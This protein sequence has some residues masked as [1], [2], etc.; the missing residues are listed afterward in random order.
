MLKEYPNFKRG[1]IDKFHE[2]L[3][4]QE[5]EIINDY[6]VYRKARGVNTESKIMDIR[7]YILHIRFIIERPLKEIDLK[8]LRELLAIINGSRLT[9]YVQNSVKTDLK[10]F[11][12]YLFPDWSMRF[13]NLDDIKLGGNSKNEEKINSETIYTKEDIETLMKHETKNFYKAFLMTQYEAGLRTKETRCLKWSDIKLN[14]DGEI[15]EINIF[16]TKTKKSRVVFVKEATFYLSKW[17]EEQENQGIKSVYVFPS[18]SKPN[19]PIDKATISTW[20]RDLSKK[21]LGRQGWNYLLR[22]S[23]ATELYRLAEQNKVSK[24]IAIKFMGHSKDMSY[25]YTH[26]DK[27]EVKEMLKNQ[28][29][30]IEDLPPEQKHK[31]EQELDTLKSLLFRFM[32]VQNSKTSEKKKQMLMNQI[33]EEAREQVTPEEFNK[34]FGY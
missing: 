11:L 9:N 12:K 30:K 17:K 3:S 13:S 32:F 28:V 22:H 23:R 18:K 20:F 19:E 2:T 7:R 26:L 16:A 27:K 34:Y 8:Q 21:S 15:S 6:L 1:E 4:K 5:K 33:L 24:D 10:N 14:A 29:Y 31:I 25:T